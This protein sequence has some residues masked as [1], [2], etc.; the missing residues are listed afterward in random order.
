MED[1]NHVRF[2]LILVKYNGTL[3]Q[4]NLVCSGRR[5]KLD[6]NVTIAGAAYD[7]VVILVYRQRS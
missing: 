2:S 1:A 7:N 3:L 5:N 6:G 4:N